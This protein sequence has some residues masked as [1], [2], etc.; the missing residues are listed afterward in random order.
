[1][2]VYQ[3]ICS[4]LTPQ[5]GVHV[6]VT[7]VDLLWPMEF[8]LVLYLGVKAVLVQG[9]LVSMPALRRY[10]NGLDTILVYRFCV[11]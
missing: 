1:M 5:E 3:R 11:D 2:R 7:L 6:R 10:V 9:I 4:V 8:L